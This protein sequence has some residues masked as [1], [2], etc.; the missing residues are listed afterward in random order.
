MDGIPREQQRHGF[1]LLSVAQGSASGGI[2]GKLLSPRFLT[3][4]RLHP[5]L[6]SINLKYPSLF[7][8]YLIDSDGFL[9]TAMTVW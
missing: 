1:N 7:Y 4:D 5:R 3:R 9:S 8:S 6:F 2:S